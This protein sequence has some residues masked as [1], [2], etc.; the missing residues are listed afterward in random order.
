MANSFAVRQLRENERC[1]GTLKNREKLAETKRLLTFKADQLSYVQSEI[2][3]RLVSEVTT[4]LRLPGDG[5]A[6]T[7]LAVLCLLNAGFEAFF[8][9]PPDAAVGFLWPTSTSA[10][11]ETRYTRKL[12]SVPAKRRAV[13]VLENHEYITFFKGGKDAKSFEPGKVSMV[14]PTAKLHEVYAAVLRE[15]FEV[16]EA[17]AELQELVILNGA[18]GDRLNEEGTVAPNIGS[19]PL[20]DY[21]DT[22]F[23]NR[24]RLQLRSINELNKSHIWR[25]ESERD[26]ESVINPASLT[27]KRLFMCGS[28]SI[29]GRYHCEA[30]GMRKSR[31]RSIH[32]NEEETVELDFKAM[33]PTLAYART[34]VTLEGNPYEL[35]GY[36]RKLVKKALLICL[37]AA[38]RQAA[39]KAIF[40]EVSKM[41]EDE[42]NER[43]PAL[44]TSSLI[45]ELERKHWLIK[46]LFFTQAWQALSFQESE[47]MSEIITHCI[48]FK[49]PVLPIH[50]GLVCRAVDQDF[51][52][53]VMSE[54]FASHAYERPRIM[55]VD[56]AGRESELVPPSRRH[57]A[58]PKEEAHESHD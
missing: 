36:S 45:E 40:S 39:R 10:K 41:Y 12:F 11:K 23:T 42:Y 35:A 5:K 34:E 27:L 30:Q 8:N 38:T 50:D 56:S 4:G 54:S 52:A 3:E 19:S 25:F 32:I 47:I 53:E 31:R 37:N 48:H 2:T 43:L 9:Q 24:T 14:L 51:F 21:E 49:K 13:A 28:F 15:P 44:V 16:V 6:N 26:G 57:A 20:A 58:Q 7:R 33:L 46:H 29:Y 22:E 18:R 1:A 17:G 55:M